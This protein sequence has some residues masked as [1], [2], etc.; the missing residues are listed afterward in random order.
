[1]LG[2]KLIH[3]S[4]KGLCQ[5][6]KLVLLEYL[7]VSAVFEKVQILI[8]FPKINSVHKGL[9][10]LGRDKIATILQTTFLNA[11]SWIKILE[12]R[13]HL[14]F[15]EVCSLGSNW[16]QVSIGSDNGLVLNRQQTIIWTK[17]ESVQWHIYGSPSLNELTVHVLYAWTAY[18]NG[19]LYSYLLPLNLILYW[20]MVPSCGS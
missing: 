13:F 18:S 12:F 4:K 6:K 15:I 14:N 16:Q 9:T 1:M 10:H 2:L 17:S 3:V 8:H 7:A 5:H 11:F 19:T 20:N